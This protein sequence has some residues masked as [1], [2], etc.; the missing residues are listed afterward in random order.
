MKKIINYAI[1]CVIFTIFVVMFA[2]QK[3]YLFMAMDTLILF[4][5]FILMCCEIKEYKTK[6][7]LESLNEPDKLKPKD[8][9]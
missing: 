4:M 2:I 1:W 5:N 9:D 3:E 8:H 6:Q 7:R